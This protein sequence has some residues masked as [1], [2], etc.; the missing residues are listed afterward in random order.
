[1]KKPLVALLVLMTVGG[2]FSPALAATLPY[3]SY[4]YDYYKTG[5]PSPAAYV[6]A[7]SLGAEDFGAAPFLRPTDI[8]AADDGRLYIC[9]AGNGRIVV[10]NRD[11]KF[12]R[13]IVSFDNNGAADGFKSPAG[14]CVT[15]DGTLYVADT[16]N[17]RIVVLDPNDSLLRIIAYQ[18][19]DNKGFYPLRV[20]ADAAG[21]VFVVARG[22]YE[23]I[24]S[25]NADG[26]LSGYLGTIKVNVSPLDLFWKT[27]ASKQQKSQMQLF[28]PTEFTNL[29]IDASGFIF[30]TNV[31]QNVAVNA[32]KRLNPSGADV[33]KSKTDYPIVG[34]H[35]Y[36]FGARNP[37]F[38]GRT[39]FVDVVVRDS[40]IFSAVDTA[41][42]RV[43][44]Y[45]SEGNI[46]YIF[47]VLGNQE[48]TFRKPAAI[49]VLGD[50]ILVLD[51]ETGR[52]A[53]FTPTE[54]GRNINRAVAMRYDGDESE[55]V[56]YWEKVLEV[57]ANYEV[58][59]AGIGK[60]LLAQK[61]NKEAM[62]YFKL[63]MDKRYYS[64]AFRRYRNEV[65]KGMF[66]YLIT[67]VAVVGVGTFAL[68]RRKRARRAVK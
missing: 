4:N 54:Y 35:S 67:G 55:A 64:I 43:F 10:L 61:R 49:D 50:Q 23:G 59:Y 58:A 56:R 21:R 30:A 17:R 8:Y 34:D 68:V 51:E 14:I 25:F 1:M 44:T 2:I 65:L 53:F 18:P 22:I 60:S 32:I 13:E 9:D 29:D 20:T 12:E 37:M 36:Y 5:V 16:E 33:I 45:D 40:G 62:A 28:I 41:R 7:G 27:F 66:G 47:G 48:G 6:P 19:A 63:A 11:L 57:D 52:I 38:S 46:L 39:R 26:A 3:E 15:A 24:M 42:G 31:D